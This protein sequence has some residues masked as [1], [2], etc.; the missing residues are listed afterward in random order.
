MSPRICGET[1]KLGDKNGT[2]RC[3]NFGGW[4]QG[5]ETVK[6]FKHTIGVYIMRVK[7]PIKVT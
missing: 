6:L 7:V 4:E 3:L 2:M 1:D 5:T